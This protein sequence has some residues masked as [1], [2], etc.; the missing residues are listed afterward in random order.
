MASLGE[1]TRDILTQPH[2]PLQKMFQQLIVNNE[3]DLEVTQTGTTLALAASQTSV[4]FHT[5]QPPQDQSETEWIPEIVFIEDAADIDVADRVAIRYFDTKNGVGI[6]I[7]N[8][9]P[10][11]KSAPAGMG[12]NQWLWPSNFPPAQPTA[13]DLC[14]EYRPLRLF[15]DIAGAPWR[16]LLIDVQTTATVGTRQF[17]VRMAY[18]RRPSTR[19]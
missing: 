2:D 3:G 1:P 7:Y 13:L 5:I 11:Q 18:R 9:K 10:S 4:P 19:V 17:N 6:Y 12:N 16:Q 8:S 15:R 14:L